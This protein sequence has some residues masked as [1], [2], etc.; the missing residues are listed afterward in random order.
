VVVLVK[1]ESAV[2]NVPKLAR[3]LHLD[4][5][6]AW[7]IAGSF[8]GGLDISSL[9]EDGNDDVGCHCGSLGGA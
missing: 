5:T 7:G 9:G 4:H 1:S 3:S 2:H 6:G 8:W